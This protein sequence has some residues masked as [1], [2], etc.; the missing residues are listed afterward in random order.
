M[1]WGDITSLLF[2]VKTASRSSVASHYALFLNVMPVKNNNR[3]LNILKPEVLES[4]GSVSE[5]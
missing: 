3:G 4:D 5:N 2:D 1:G